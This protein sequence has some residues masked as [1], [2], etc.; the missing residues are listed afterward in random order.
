MEIALQPK[1]SSENSQISWQ[2]LLSIRMW[3]KQPQICLAV[4]WPFMLMLSQQ[5]RVRVLQTFH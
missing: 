3:E 1:T 5:L 2:Q 4:E